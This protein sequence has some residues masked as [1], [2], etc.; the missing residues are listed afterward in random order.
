VPGKSVWD[1]ETRNQKRTLKRGDEGNP[2]YWKGKSLTESWGAN[3]EK[4][5]GAP[6]R[7]RRSGGFGGSRE[8][9][10]NRAKKSRGN[11][12]GGGGRLTH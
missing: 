4:C 11:T 8:E 5:G 12:L 9:G 1:E 7:G 10:M 3:W 6:G 2:S